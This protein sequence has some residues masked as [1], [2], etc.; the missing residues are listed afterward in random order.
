MDEALALEQ[1]LDLAQRLD[2]RVC[3]EWLGGE[4]GG[5]CRLKGQ[6]VLYVDE[7][8]SINEQA[9]RTAAQMMLLPGLD[10]IYISPQLRQFIEDA[11][12]QP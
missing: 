11:G 9:A 8:A 3:R 2:V 6:Y 7:A 1:L 4:G 10:E 12:E 5:L